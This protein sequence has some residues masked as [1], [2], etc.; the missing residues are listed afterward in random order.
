VAVTGINA[1][2][3]VITAGQLKLQPGSPITP[4]F[5]DGTAPAAESNKPSTGQE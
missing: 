1:G 3:V 2:D 4:I 5:V